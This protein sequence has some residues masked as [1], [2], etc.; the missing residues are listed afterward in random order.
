MSGKVGLR[1]VMMVQIMA[2]AGERIEATQEGE[3]FR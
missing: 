1:V 3:D 2:S